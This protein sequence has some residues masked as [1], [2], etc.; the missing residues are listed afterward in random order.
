VIVLTILS[1]VLAII[2]P[3]APF[4][5]YSIAGVT[6]LML[7]WRDARAHPERSGGRSSTSLRSAQNA[8]AAQSKDAGTFPRAQFLAAFIAGLITAP[9]LFYLYSATQA[10]AVLRAWSQQNQT[11]SPPPIDYLL[12]NGLLWIFAFFGARQAWRHKT[13][14]D[15]LLLVWIL[16]TLPLLYAPFPLQRR[17]S[18][19][20]HVPIGILAAI[21][22]TEIVRAK[23]PR[24]ALIGV[25]LLTSIFI[26]LALFGGAAAR[27]PR[28]YLTTNEMA[29]LNWLQTNA[30]RDAVV[31]AS[32]ELG[33]FIP[34]FAGQR[35]VYG[36]PY[37]TVEAEVREQQV[38][39]FFAGAIDQAR[40]IGDHAVTYI[41]VGPR[42]QKLGTLDLQGLPLEEVFTAGDVIVYRVKRET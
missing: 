32:P 6:L 41:V 22:L 14:W 19:G 28:I 15:V 34:A 36:H 12:G 2:Q 7:W 27:D 10:D 20:L 17:L 23:W 30:S 42:E 8:P 9:L 29:A 40:M 11:P 25:T 21:G 26:E 4:A 38:K 39:D 35:V 16:V 33:G 18:L 1:L 13:D 5:V 24:R 37:E 31:L 3:F